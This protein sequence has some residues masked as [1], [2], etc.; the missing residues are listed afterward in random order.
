MFLLNLDDDCL[1]NMSPFFNILLQESAEA[2]VLGSESSVDYI[3][4]DLTLPHRLVVRI[5]GIIL[6]FR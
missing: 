6:W 1:H 4:D 3:W 5:N 2:E